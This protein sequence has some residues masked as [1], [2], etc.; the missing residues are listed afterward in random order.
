MAVSTRKKKLSLSVD[1]PFSKAKK[2]AKEFGYN[3]MYFHALDEA[4]KL[5]E[6][7]Q[8]EYDEAV[9]S[10]DQK[11]IEI[12]RQELEY[13]IDCL[14]FSTVVVATSNDKDEQMA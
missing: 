4:L 13:S 9:E 8:H 3:M 6:I 1:G 5:L 7:A 2:A 14:Q 12:K 10:G 11:M